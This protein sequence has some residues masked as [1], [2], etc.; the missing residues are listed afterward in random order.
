MSEIKTLGDNLMTDA[1]FGE[2][3]NKECERQWNEN[4]SNKYG[5]WNEQNDETKEDYY[6]QLSIDYADLLGKACFDCRYVDEENEQ[7]VCRCN[8]CKHYGRKVEKRN[9]CDYFSNV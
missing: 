5:L 2:Y 3:I 9:Y 8:H 1:E 4:Q 7:L 6:I